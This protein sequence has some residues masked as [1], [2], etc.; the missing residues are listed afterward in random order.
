MDAVSPLTAVIALT[1]AEAQTKKARL[2][3]LGIIWLRMS[4]ITA[5][6]KKTAAVAV[7]STAA[8]GASA[9]L[10]TP[11]RVKVQM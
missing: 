9:A 3:L 1:A 2:S 10:S 5:P 8:S 6:H 4:V 7:I 11:K